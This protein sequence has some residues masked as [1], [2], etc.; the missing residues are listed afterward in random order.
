[1][2]WLLFFCGFL[3]TYAV[4]R[5]QFKFLFSEKSALEHIKQRRLPWIW[6]IWRHCHYWL[7]SSKLSSDESGSSTDSGVSVWVT[8]GASVAVAALVN[9]FLRKNVYPHQREDSGLLQRLG[10]THTSCTLRTILPFWKIRLTLSGDSSVP[11]HGRLECMGWKSLTRGLLCRLMNQPASQWVN[12]QE[13]VLPEG[14]AQNE[15]WS[16]GSSGCGLPTSSFVSVPFS[17]VSFARLSGLPDDLNTWKCPELMAAWPR[18]LAEPISI[19]CN[20]VS[21]SHN[22]W[23]NKILT[24][25]GRIGNEANLHDIGLSGHSDTMHSKHIQ[26]LGHDCRNFHRLKLNPVDFGCA[27]AKQGIPRL[28]LRCSQPLSFFTRQ[29]F[30]LQNSRWR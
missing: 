4:G 28:A 14:G 11:R 1:M 13:S 12:S 8:S 16:Q 23:A 20:G 9:T 18:A 10:S 22:R 30:D 15:G 27:A 26:N 25:N 17:A 7:Q 2:Y 29:L 3:C 19:I 6:P 21:T 24:G 5:M